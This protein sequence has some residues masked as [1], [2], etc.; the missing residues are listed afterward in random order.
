MENVKFGVDRITGT[1]TLEKPKL[2]CLSIPYE[3]GWEA[4]VDGKKEKIIKTNYMYSG[5]ALDA[6]RHEVELVYHTPGFRTG[7]IVSFVCGILLLAISLRFYVKD[8]RSA[9]VK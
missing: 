5:I 3:K 8:K 7:L 1:I 9:H 2:L 4:Y 6:G